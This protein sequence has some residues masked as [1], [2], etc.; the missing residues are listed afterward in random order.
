MEIKTAKDVASLRIGI[1]AD[2]ANA[3][4][5]EGFETQLRRVNTPKNAPTL[6]ITADPLLATHRCADVRQQLSNKLNAGYDVVVAM[7]G[8]PGTSQYPEEIN[9]LLEAWSQAK[10][11]LLLL[12]SPSP[13]TTQEIID[14]WPGWEALSRRMNQ[15]VAELKKAVQ[16]NDEYLV[17]QSGEKAYAQIINTID[18]GKS[19]RPVLASQPAQPVLRVQK[20]VIEG[21]SPTLHLVS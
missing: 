13:A 4:V 7:L 3:A 5:E 2:A 10:K 21:M 14:R 11:P 8:V 15:P 19:L 6:E 16:V 17:A 20:P 12:A 18:T 1:I 9:N